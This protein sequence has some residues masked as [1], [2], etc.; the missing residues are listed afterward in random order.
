MKY[1]RE[2]N[3]IILAVSA[4]TSDIA[5]SQ[6]IQMA[7]EVDPNR[8]RTVAVRTKLDLVD[9]GTEEEVRKTLA[10]E[11]LPFKKGI[12]GVINRSQ[13]D[14]NNNSTIQDSIEKE[15]MFFE[16]HYPEL[17]DTHRTPNL[18]SKLQRILIEHIQACIPGLE[19]RNS[20]FKVLAFRTI[21]YLY[22]V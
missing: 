8:K 6:S 3:C 9:E 4:A 16:E 7:K 15:R 20:H 1:M 17:L 11:I 2:K 22:L 12:V 10:G 19:V 18:L 13:K 21:F 14:I 5:T